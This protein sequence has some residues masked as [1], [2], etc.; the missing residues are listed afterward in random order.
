MNTFALEAND[1]SGN[2]TTKNYQVSV[3]ATCSTHTY[4]LS[5]NLTQKVEGA[6]TWAYEWNAEGQLKRVLK[7]GVEQAR[8]S[9]DPNGRRVEKVAGGVTT[10]YLY[11]GEDIWV[12]LF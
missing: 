6:D 7:N 4:D 3:S 11:D 10:S 5:G 8:F 12:R 1:Q 9:Y 2:V